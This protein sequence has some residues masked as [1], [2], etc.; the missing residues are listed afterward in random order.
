VKRPN[1]AASL[2][3]DAKTSARLG[4]VRQHGTA[5]EL[6]VRRVMTRLGHRY[7][8]TN[9]DLPGSPDLANRTQRWALFVHGCYWHAHRGCRRAT[10]PTRNRDYWE[11]KFAA[12]R[13]RDARAVR[14]L[15]KLGFLVITLWECEL[16]DS[17]ALAHRL[18]RDLR[19]H[20][21]AK[22]PS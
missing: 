5:P 8:T 14:S 7:R 10:I 11:A 2:Q 15:R 21:A 6:A 17:D 20:R 3:T 13:E 1:G 12:N 22:R 18:R 19:A 4:R 16:G 9:R